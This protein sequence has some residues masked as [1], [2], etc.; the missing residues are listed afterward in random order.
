ML[1]TGIKKE[2]MLLSRKGKL[3]GIIAVLFIFAISDPL[4]MKILD[5][6]MSVMPD[7]YASS[8]AS[9]DN[10]D[11]ITS[12]GA[13]F[14]DMSPAYLASQCVNEIMNTGSIVILLI[15]MSAAGGEQKKRSVIIPRCSGLN[16]SMYVGP[17]FILYPFLIFVL[18]VAAVFLGTGVSMLLFE[19]SVD[20]GMITL[21]AV[22]AGIYVAFISVLQLTIGL[23]T[24]RP[25]AAVIASIAASMLIPGILSMFRVDRFNPFA[26]PSLAVSAAFSSGGSTP[27]AGG[28]LQS[29]AESSL[30]SAGVDMFDLA[31]S[32][33]VTVVISVI[34]YFTTVFALSS[35]EIDNEGDEPVL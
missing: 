4:L 23:G 28:T 29:I 27:S 33:G 8:G 24:G 17:K 20:F 30:S 1:K 7:I 9:Q 15:L 2:W 19:G 10:L 12:L 5:S 32:L 3:A 6:M 16:P 13:M 14:G 35:K 21:S 34:L 11:A 26:L 25:G 22:T 31:V 18:S